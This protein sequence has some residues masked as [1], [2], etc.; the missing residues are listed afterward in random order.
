[1]VQS[2]QLPEI[3]MLMQRKLTLAT[4]CLTAMASLTPALSAAAVNLDIEV[5]P[6]APRVEV[7][8]APRPGFY[9][10]P[11]YWAW[12]DHHHVWVGGHWIHERRG[13]HWVPEHWIQAGPR[14]H[15]AP[16]HWER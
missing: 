5:A 11:G 15:F 10:A 13:Y 12:R 16:G 7:V 3:D 2:T 8:P 14:W 4:L 6:P 1:L 9:W